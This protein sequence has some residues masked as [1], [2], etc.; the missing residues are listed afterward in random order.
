MKLSRTGLILA[1]ASPLI[2]ILVIFGVIVLTQDSNITDF[3]LDVFDFE[4]CAAKGYPIMESF[5]RQCRTDDGRLFTEILQPNAFYHSQDSLV[6]Y[7]V[8][9]TNI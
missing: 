3:D 9:S 6:N 5:P 2:A 1:V 4:S 7:L 8:T